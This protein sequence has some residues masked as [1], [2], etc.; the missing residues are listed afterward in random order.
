M[1]IIKNFL[2]NILDIFSPKISSNLRLIKIKKSGEYQSFLALSSVISNSKNIID[3][4][5]RVGFFTFVLKNILRNK[6]RDYHLFEPLPLNILILQKL[7]LNNSSTYIHP[8]AISD[9]NGFLGFELNKFPLI[10]TN[11]ALN[12]ISRKKTKN[13][14]FI[15]IKLDSLFKIIKFN[16]NDF[17]KIDVEGFEYYV[18][19]GGNEFIDR[20]N[21]I[22]FIEIELRHLS[23]SK[24]DEMLNFLN[25]KNYKCFYF[26]Y[27]VNQFEA[28]NLDSELLERI[29]VDIYNS[30][31]Y[32]NNFLFL[33]DKYHNSKI[34]KII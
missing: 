4:G 25:S 8:Y 5:A 2:V 1:Y 19:K 32:I 18:I 24:I 9:K 3:I 10:L 26:N 6:K 14:T 7:Y 12:K 20:F 22:F 27:E 13:I 15:S 17:I 28:I 30:K 33:N 29:Q 31:K 34:N 21:P 11:N 16:K 23:K